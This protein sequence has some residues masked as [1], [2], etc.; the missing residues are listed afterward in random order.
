MTVAAILEAAARI[1]ERR[2][3]EGFNTNAVAETA[4]VS[5]GSLYQ[6]FPGKDALVAALVEADARLFHAALAAAASEPGDLAGDVS[7][8]VAVAAAHQMRRPRLARIL[9]FEESRLAL[10]GEAAVQRRAVAALVSGVLARH[11]RLFPGLDPAEA[12]GDLAAMTRALVDEA[13]DRGETDSA[14]VRRRAERTALGYLLGPA[15]RRRVGGRP[16]PNA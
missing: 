9:D 1:L 13:V 10:T 16:V 8:L 12:A 7:R 4:G 14:A 15:A 3:L 6:Y 2:G 5:I 11:A